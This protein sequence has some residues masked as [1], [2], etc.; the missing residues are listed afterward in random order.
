MTA[1]HVWRLATVD[2]LDLQA[3]MPEHVAATC[4]A[5][6]IGGDP[7]YIAFFYATTCVAMETDGTVMIAAVWN[8]EN[9]R[10]TLTVCG[11]SVFH[12]IVGDLNHE[13]EHY[14]YDFQDDILADVDD[15]N[16]GDALAVQR[17]T[18]IQT[19][20]DDL[21]EDVHIMLAGSMAQRLGDTFRPSAAPTPRHTVPTACTSNV[22][23]TCVGCQEKHGLVV[24][25]PCGHVN[26][27]AACATRVTRM[28]NI[29]ARKCPICR[30][31]VTSFAA[32]N[33]PHSTLVACLENRRT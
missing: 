4:R 22:V 6:G 19:I 24:F 12:N 3:L 11:P 10:L 8:V 32:L 14:Q 5:H 1:F 30:E 16:G 28:P 7:D 18:D 2:Q 31:I 26:M 27:C 29:D 9:S 17:A 20:V 21:M 33:I 23:D 15:A 25:T 13:L